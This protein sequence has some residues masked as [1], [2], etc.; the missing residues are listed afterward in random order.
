MKKVFL[1]IVALV[2][3]LGLGACG[4]NGSATENGEQTTTEWTTKKHSER[5]TAEG[6][7]YYTVPTETSMISK[8]SLTGPA[9][10]VQS[11]IKLS[12]SPAELINKL[13]AMEVQLKDP[14]DNPSY[15]PEDDELESIV[16]TIVKD[17]R[18]YNYDGSFSFKTKEDDA[19]H[20]SDDGKLIVL[21][22]RSTRF[23]TPEG[24]KIGDSFKNVLEA[25]K[26][27]I[28]YDDNG[29]LRVKTE[30]GYYIFSFDENKLVFWAFAENE[31][32]FDR[33]N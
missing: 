11:E 33:G 9:I 15:H 29:G 10:N 25:Y 18:W 14:Y 27:E 4:S 24:I 2:I 32:G 8:T 23:S 21:S 19:F 5:T 22:L 1:G 31:S 12:I 6:A 28:I 17:G 13:D 20:F 16:G 30:N 3:L 7:N 26:N